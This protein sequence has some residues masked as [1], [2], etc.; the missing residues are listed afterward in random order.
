[1]CSFKPCIVVSYICILNLHK[2]YYVI[3]LILF[4]TFFIHHYVFT[5]VPVAVCIFN[6]LLLTVV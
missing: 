4:L 5:L 6:L 3:Y 1:M 2:W